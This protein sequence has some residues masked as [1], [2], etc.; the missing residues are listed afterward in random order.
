MGDNEEKWV[1]TVHARE[2]VWIKM[3]ENL[4]QDGLERIDIWNDTPPKFE[5]K[6]GFRAGLYLLN[7][8][9]AHRGTVI[10]CAGGAFI[11]KSPNEAR[12]VAEYFKNAGFNAGIL[13]YTV[14]RRGPFPD[15]GIPVV[16]QAAGEDAL[17]AVRYLRAHA[18]ELGISGNM[19][20]IGGFSAGG[21]AV[22]YAVSQYDAGN[23]E[24]TDPVCKVSSRPDAAL[25]MY[26]APAYTTTLAGYQQYNAAT[27]RTASQTDLIR[28]L[29]P[30]CPPIFIFQTNED[31]PRHALSLAWEMAS[32]GLQHEVHTFRSGRHGGGLYDGGDANTPHI[33]HTA[34]WAELAVGWLRELGF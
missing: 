20:A 15:H 26:G 32:R 12:P 29:K 24:S 1:K 11:F 28:N 3:L 25:L 31:D 21:R 22:Q 4:T 34:Q 9:N 8:R 27:L 6:Y 5:E 33:P 14:D 23:P 13:D 17:R 19:I 16:R 18:E 30:D 2:A 10:I 7:A